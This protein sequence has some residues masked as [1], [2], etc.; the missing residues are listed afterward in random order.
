MLMEARRVVEDGLLTTE[1]AAAFLG[2][3]RSF[4]YKLM[5]TGELAFVKIGKARRI[6]KRAL[7]ELA[8]ANL[9]GGWR[10]NG[11]DVV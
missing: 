11:G 1:E 2:V 10:R 4:L 5:Q 9:Q 6:P 7:I 8:A 3:R